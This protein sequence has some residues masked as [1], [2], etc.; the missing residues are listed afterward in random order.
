MPDNSRAP[1]DFFRPYGRLPPRRRLL[2]ALL[3]VV[4]ALGIA[5]LLIY[6][7]GGVHPGPRSNPLPGSA[8][9]SASSARADI[10]RCTAGQTEDCVGS[11]TRVIAAPVAAPE[12]A[13]GAANQAAPKRGH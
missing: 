9:S 6:R 4:T 3:A 5:W 8:A 1:S 10:G 11:T 12:E 2:I 7:P 13:P